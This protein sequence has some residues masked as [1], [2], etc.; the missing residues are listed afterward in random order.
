[1]GVLNV[2]PDSFYDGG[3]YDTPVKAI[4][5]VLAMEREGADIIDIGGESTRPG[6][7]DVTVEEELKRTI[8]IIEEL[9]D[10]LSV[11]ISID[12]RKAEVAHKAL[13]AGAAMVN[14]ISG[15]K[16]DSRMAGIVSDAGVPVVVMHMKGAPKVMQENPVYNDL[17]A[18]IIDSL[19]RSLNLG[20]KAGI[21]MENFIVD[22]G[23]GFGKTWE[24]NFVILQRLHELHSLNCPLLI[25][26]SRK[27]F[28]G[29]ALD[30]K[31]E[32]R[33]FGTAGA[34]AASILNGTQIVRVHDVKEM[35]HVV[36]I[37][38]RIRNK[39]E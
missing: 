28:I 29:R 1:M 5:R 14:D 38:D 4:D 36:R 34:V 12:T 22:P 21:S 39:S 27:S 20:L 11:P 32:D 23:I 30:L 19:R 3:K 7:D 25:G 13:Q 18:E 31:E 26:V 6:S 9:K 8:P 2:T 37:V 33:L 10:R 16:Y 15:L 24:D 17:M 35:N